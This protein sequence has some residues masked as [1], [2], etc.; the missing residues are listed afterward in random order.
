MSL[1]DL[2][3]GRRLASN[4]TNGQQI[5]PLIGVAVLGL[6]ALSSAA[7]G[8]EAALTVLL[9]AGI[10][11]VR[12]IGPVTF[13]IIILLLILF[14][15][16][17][18]TISAYP[19]GGGSYTVAKENLGTIAGLIA[20]AGLSLDYILNVGV[21]I[22]AGTGALVSAIPALLPFTKEICLVTLAIL[23]IAN[24]RG[25]RE[26]GIA[27]I[28]PT[29]LFIGCLF[30][31]IVAGT[32][33]S[34]AAQGHPL[35][36][37]GPQQQ[38]PIPSAAGMWIFLRSFAS[39]CTAMTGVEA[40]SNGV[41][42]FKQPEVKQAKTTLSIIILTLVVFLSG[43]AYVVH[44]YAIGATPPGEP[45]YQSI[46]SRIFEAVFGRGILY[47]VSICA[48]I[49]VLTLSA[50]T[51]FAGFPRVCRLLALDH[52][53]P[54]V[55][56]HRGRRLVYAEGIYVLIV[57]DA[58]LIAAFKGVTDRLIP[59][60]AIGAFA[61]FTCSQAGMVMHWWKRRSDKRAI[62]SLGI[63][64]TGAVCTLCAFL[65]IFISKF[66]EGAWLTLLVV[67]ILVMMFQ[68]ERKYTEKVSNKV[69]LNKPIDTRSLTPPVVVLPI[70]SLDRAAEKGMRL[71]MEIASECFVIHVVLDEDSGRD[72]ERKWKELVEDPTR[73]LNRRPP[74]LVIL[75]SKY[76]ELVGPILAFIAQLREKYPRRPIAVIIPQLIEPRWYHYIFRNTAMLLE[77]GVLWKNWPD[78]FVVS[79]PIHLTER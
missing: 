48:V 49:M 55:F 73:A 3:F 74:R 79:S 39:G 69:R 4:E 35:P 31:A 50:N 23:S 2:I 36:V 78:V 60:F 68:R 21:A 18:Q 59:L 58:I 70:S 64:L 24:L 9:P 37:I 33:R 5:G 42:L 62:Y 77:A 1:T 56:S 25:V 44:H 66:K 22:S 19:H 61:A 32:V 46:L 17:R 20:A 53:L 63:N 14:F 57:I 27:F 67:P 29:Y 13:L 8:P 34:V 11:G 45:G 26:A 10:N 52:F 30:I 12:A 54:K 71:G 15:S 76:R 16:Y 51:S 72:I 7:Y 75:S 6:D 38:L 41:P 40:V 28:V 43:I 47:Y 65:V